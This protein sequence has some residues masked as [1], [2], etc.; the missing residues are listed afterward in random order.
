MRLALSASFT[1]ALFVTPS[2]SGAA[3]TPSPGPRILAPE[4]RLP[5]SSATSSSG[6]PENPT[7]TTLWLKP[8][9]DHQV[10][11]SNISESMTPQGKRG[12]M[13]FTITAS[14]NKADA[15]SILALYNKNEVIS[16]A[17]IYVPPSVVYTL[18]NGAIKSYSESSGP[19]GSSATFTLAEQK[20]SVKDGNSTQTSD[21]VPK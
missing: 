19:S 3:P 2:F 17:R 18:T 16:E 5:M 13:L 7:T 6:P 21:C 1:A 4:I 8:V 15:V 12:C 20:Y 10:T 11:L 14:L 9:V